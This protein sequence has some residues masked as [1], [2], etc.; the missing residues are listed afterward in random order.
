VGLGGEGRREGASDPSRYAQL[1]VEGFERY[2][3]DDLVGARTAWNEAAELAPDRP[4]A[5]INLAQV[6]KREGTLARPT[7]RMQALVRERA[8]LQ[9]A[10]ATAPGHCEALVNLGLVEAHTSRPSVARAIIERARLACGARSGFVSLDEAALAAAENHPQLALAA[11]EQ[12]AAA[13]QIDTVDKRRE[14][15]ADLEHD[16]LFWMV[17][18]NDRF[19][20]VI[21][22]LR[23][24]LGTQ[25]PV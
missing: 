17:R 19:L 6:E 16:Q 21:A 4:E 5:W 12:A 23:R 7:Q 22:R 9:R 13:L 18:G 10:L 25:A 2:L 14:A 3:I 15:L 1:L 20:A 11:I 24:S 8:L